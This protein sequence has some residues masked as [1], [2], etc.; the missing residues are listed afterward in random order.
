[1]DIRDM[2]S[3]SNGKFDQG[4]GYFAGRKGGQTGF[5]RRQSEPGEGAHGCKEKSCILDKIR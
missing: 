2:T 3:M 1:M 5:Y 4:I